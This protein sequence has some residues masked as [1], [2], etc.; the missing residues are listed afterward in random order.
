MAGPKAEVSIEL[1]RQGDAKRLTVKLGEKETA[2]HAAKLSAN[3]DKMSGLSLTDPSA[4]L[5]RRYEIPLGVQGP[6]VTDV[7]AGS[8]AARAGFRPGDIVI[9]LN[10]QRLSSA[11]DFAE[12]YRRARGTVAA[13][14]Y[15]QG[16]SL[17]LA[18]RK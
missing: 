11:S 1:I 4:E 9:E 17:Y 2:D 6:V 12:A 13:L 16:N 7:E 18:F 10:R 8:T 3:D 5:R 14:I 15:R